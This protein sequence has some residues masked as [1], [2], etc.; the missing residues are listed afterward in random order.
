MRAAVLVAERD[1]SQRAASE[2]DLRR[3]HVADQRVRAVAADLLLVNQLDRGPRRE[4]VEIV[5]IRERILQRFDDWLGDA[6]LGGSLLEVVLDREGRLDRANEILD[7]P[8]PSLQD[9]G[10]EARGGHG[11]FFV[12]VVSDAAHLAGLGIFVKRQ[13]MAAVKIA[14][15]NDALNVR[16]PLMRV[17][18]L[19]PGFAEVAL[20]GRGAVKRS[21]DSDRGRSGIDGFG[22]LDDVGGVLASVQ[23][24]AEGVERRG[25]SLW[26]C[27]EEK[28]QRRAG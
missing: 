14:V 3:L 18:R 24:G 9:A 15:R 1:G 5:A 2:P 23:F 7:R 22:L 13:R 20:G 4:P 21:T 27:L 19:H 8:Q 10:A 26:I 11:G 28:K 16:R 12:K 6:V 17:A 25:K